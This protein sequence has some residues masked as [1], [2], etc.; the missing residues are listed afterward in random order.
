MLSALWNHISAVPRRRALFAVGAAVLLSLCAVRSDARGGG[1]QS[2]SGGSRSRSRSRSYGGGGGFGGGYYG[3]GGIGAPSF[4][5]IVVIIIVIIV[6]MRLMARS[7]GSGGMVVFDTGASSD[8]TW[9]PEDYG[10]HSPR[11]QFEAL[12]RYDPNF[13][14]IAFT[15]FVYALYARA[16]EARGRGELVDLSPYMSPMAMATLEGAS[17]PVRDV[18]GVIVGGMKILSVTD[19]DR[20]EQVAVTVRYEANY[21]EIDAANRQQGYYAA[22]VWQLTRNR[23]LLSKPPETIAAL[24]CPRCGGALDRTPDGACAHCGVKITGGDF[25]WYV[26]QLCVEEREAR[27]PLLTSNV[28][29]EGT[30]LR[31]VYDPGLGAAVQ[32]LQEEDP[33]F[34]WERT[35]RRF[36]H[37]FMAVQEAWTSRRWEA[38]RPFETDNVFQMHR[39]WID[40]Y[41]KQ[42]LRN[43][44]EQI[45]V[46]RIEPVKLTSDRFYDAFTVRVVASMVDYT[47]DL[48]G[49]VV[50][51]SPHRQ[52]PFTEYW[53]YIRRRGVQENRKED[54]S[55]PN[56]GGPLQV[57]MAGTCDYCGGKIVSGDFDWVLSR[58]EQD[59]AYVG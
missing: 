51:G 38:A 2:Y 17:G 59:E 54:T 43:V 44:L 6:V 10:A 34:D 7:G 3:G 1:G 23:D 13:S 30:E 53:I 57:S 25:D 31:T 39:Y 56:C 18:T 58:I 52:R 36:Y 50:S 21:T 46:S 19:P 16:H 14:E 28:P 41:R 32:R 33:G 55:C 48:Q 27:G 22:E 9:A 11:R 26:E 49:K 5:T 40:A 20:A 42:G 15:D 37:I 35:N 45:A 47:V 4:L 29:E 12:R 24:H 8:D